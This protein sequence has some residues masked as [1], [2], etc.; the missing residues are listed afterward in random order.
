M[1]KLQ[2][3]YRWLSAF[4]IDLLRFKRAVRIFPAVL[5]EYSVLKKQ[6]QE[7]VAKY[8][9]KFSMPQLDDK[10]SSSGVAS[11]HYFHQD[12]LVAKKIFHR[13]PTPCK[14]PF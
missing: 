11:G 6:N 4:G 3:L 9:L 5:G 10:Y 2:S 7:A 13:N 1:R 14:F 12:L 8:K